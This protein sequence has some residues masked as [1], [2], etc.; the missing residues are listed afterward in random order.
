[1]SGRN[2]IGDRLGLGRRYE[3]LPE[4]S[5]SPSDRNLRPSQLAVP[6]NLASSRSPYLEERDGEISPENNGQTTWEAPGFAG[7]SLPV[8]SVEGTYGPRRR[9]SGSLDEIL[10]QPA[11]L[12]PY[13][14][15]DARV[16]EEFINPAPYD[17]TD[18]TPLTDPRHLQT[19][20]GASTSQIDLSPDER[21]SFQ[22]IRLSGQHSPGML[23]DDLPLA[24]GGMSQSG[25]RTPRGSGSKFAR[26][27]S[28]SPSS[29]ESPLTKAGTIVRKMSQRIVN[30]SNEPEVVEQSIR[31]RSSAKQP[32]MS[33]IFAPS[34]SAGPD[35][36]RGESSPSPI[37]KAPPLASAGKRQR[38][39]QQQPN[40]LKGRSL[41]IF[42]PNNLVRRKLCDVLVH[43]YVLPCW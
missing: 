24:E 8:G 17:E 27:H 38:D 31:R 42:P 5:P 22:S 16:S 4:S 35:A 33:D 10:E 20:G 37:E 12:E 28:L 13:I 9:T 14:L 11:E 39:W 26:Q 32:P 18:T 43:P 30:L 29:A 6:I 3:R 19:P 2:S 41:G 36:E 1:M 15:S 21:T 7:L 40:P 34:V 23:G 25:L